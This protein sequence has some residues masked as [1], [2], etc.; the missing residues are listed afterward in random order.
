MATIKQYRYQLGIS[1]SELARRANI[2]TSTVSRAEE[3][4]PIQELKA[5]QIARALSEF[6]GK[7]VSISDV[8]GLRVY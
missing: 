2:A 4:F 8:D 1:M 6:L 5:A 7:E 3:G